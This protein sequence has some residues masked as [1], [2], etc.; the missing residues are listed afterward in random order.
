M[1]VKI[2]TYKEFKEAVIEKFTIRY[3]DSEKY[4]LDFREA[5]K[6]NRKMDAIQLTPI[7]RKENFCDIS[8]SIDSSIDASSFIMSPS[9]YIN[10]LYEDY[11]ST[12]NFDAIIQRSFSLMEMAADKTSDMAKQIMDDISNREYIKSHVV[13]SLVNTENNAK[14]LESVP[15]REVFDLSIV[16]RVVLQTE[17]NNLNSFMIHESFA[18]QLG[19]SESDLYSLAKENTENFFPTVV[20]SIS[21]VFLEMLNKIDQNSLEFLMLSRAQKEILDQSDIIPPMLVVGNSFGIYGSTTLLQEKI[22]KDLSE[23]YN[24]NLVIYPS[25]I[26]ELIVIPVKDKESALDISDGGSV[27]SSVNK[28]VDLN[29]RLSNQVY[30]YDKDLEKIEIISDMDLDLNY[31]EDIDFDN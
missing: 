31:D 22:F 17:D 16:Y 24:E 15:H 21:D 14:L 5:Y 20:K 9:L 29:E 3:A 25:S 6:T 12:E 7:I 27:V 19:L 23:K 11:L 10:N 8:S 13:Y 2:V 26:H 4:A 28:E 18:N 30:Y 1:E